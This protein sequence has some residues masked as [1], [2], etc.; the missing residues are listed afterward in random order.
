MA[1]NKKHNITPI[2]IKKKIKDITDTL[3]REHHNAVGLLM[4]TDE[5]L[6]NKNPK[7]FI[8]VKRQEM[9]EAVKDLDFETAALIRDEI[10]M[11]EAKL[12]KKK[13]PNI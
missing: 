10:R 11:L 6:F 3:E 2:S 13:Q 7:K 5:A 9:E 4:E 12:E 1:Y 8:K